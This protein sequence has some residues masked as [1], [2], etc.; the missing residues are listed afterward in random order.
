MANDG[1][2]IYCG[3]FGRLKAASEVGPARKLVNMQAGGHTYLFSLPATL[4][5]DEIVRSRLLG[6]INSKEQHAELKR[7]EVNNGYA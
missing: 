4:G 6:M 5:V 7:A 3:R 1:E 2:I